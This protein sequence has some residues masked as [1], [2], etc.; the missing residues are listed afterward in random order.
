MHVR[1]CMNKQ[2]AV[3]IGFSHCVRACVCYGGGGMR[4]AISQFLDAVSR[5]EETFIALPFGRGR[6]GGKAASTPCR[7]GG[8]EAEC[9][10]SPP[11]R[12]AGPARDFLRTWHKGKQPPAPPALPCGT[13]LFV[14]VG[15]CVRR[16]TKPKWPWQIAAEASRGAPRLPLCLSAP[17]GS[18]S[19]W[20]RRGKLAARYIRDGN[21]GARGSVCVH[22]H[23]ITSL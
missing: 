10:G 15:A 22:E 13:G 18:C 1:T 11:S 7:C 3:W 17:R 4:S 2:G 16:E 5:E 14:G 12:R 23:S 20:L 8:C 9:P 19:R 21:A 6:R